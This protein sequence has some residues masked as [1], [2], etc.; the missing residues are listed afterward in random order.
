MLYAPTK[1]SIVYEPLGVV[2]IY[3]PWNVPVD[4]T[5]KPMLSAIAAGNCCFVKPSEMSPAIAMM[6]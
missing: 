4:L 5:L 6:I 2:G 1:N 3:G